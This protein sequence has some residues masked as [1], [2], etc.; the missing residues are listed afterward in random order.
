MDLYCRDIIF[1]F[2]T[3]SELAKVLRKKVFVAYMPRVSTSTEEFGVFFHE[4]LHTCAAIMERA[5]VEF[6][7]G[8]DKAY[9]YLMGFLTRKVLDATPVSFS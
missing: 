5:G 4:L 8:S 7:S 9:A 1:H 2:G 3:S 6:S